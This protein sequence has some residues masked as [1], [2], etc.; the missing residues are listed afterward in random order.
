MIRFLLAAAV[1][2]SLA[3]SAPAAF[4]HNGKIHLGDLDLSGLFARA[5]LPNAPVGGGFLTITNNGAATDC[6][7]SVTSPAAGT[8]QIHTM[9]MDG[10]IM[11]MRQVED[12]L[13][14]PAGQ[15]VTLSPGG[16]HI[17]FMALK[18]P[19]VEGETIP[20]TLTFE[21]AGSVDVQLLV[22][23]AAAATAAIPMTMH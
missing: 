8:A 22:Q 13:E 18:Q 12:G 10:D 16:L 17:M 23:D 1:A 20:V 2:V 14:I 4:A 19:F 15:T 9:Q 11:R 6:L 5:T 7:L 21:K 3:F